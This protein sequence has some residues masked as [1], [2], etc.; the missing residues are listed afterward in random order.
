MLRAVPEFR[1]CI[2][3]RG[4]FLEWFRLHLDHGAVE[5]VWLQ[6]FTHKK[7]ASELQRVLSVQS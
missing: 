5:F 2:F 6:Q 7:L 4:D 3:E 1:Q